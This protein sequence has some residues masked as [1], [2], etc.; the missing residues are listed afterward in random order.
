MKRYVLKHEAIEFLKKYHAA[1]PLMLKHIDMS[2]NEQQKECFNVDIET[3]GGN[4]R[5]TIWLHRRD[6][7][8]HMDV[9]EPDPNSILI[10]PTTPPLWLRIKQ[11]LGVE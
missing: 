3:F 10:V 1:S 7:C 9:D 6:C 4:T 11:L 8:V 5:T 2:F